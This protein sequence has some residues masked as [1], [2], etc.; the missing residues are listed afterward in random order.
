MSCAEVEVLTQQMAP[1]KA[2]ARNLRFIVCDVKIRGI[3]P[4]IDRREVGV[5]QEPDNQG[6]T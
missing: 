4:I 1:S 6:I 3:L 2:A 5:M